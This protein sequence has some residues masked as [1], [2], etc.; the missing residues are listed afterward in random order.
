MGLVMSEFNFKSAICTSREQSERLLALGLKKETADMC[1]QSTLNDVWSPY[2]P[3]AMPYSK[4]EAFDLSTDV[5][6]D[7]PAWSLG[8]LIKDLM[9]QSIGHLELAVGSDYAGY[10][11]DRC[12]SES[13]MW[14]E[15]SSETSD[16]FNN[17]I[18]TIEWLIK[19]GYF[20]KEYLV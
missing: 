15:Y 4:V 18:L 5:F 8:R 2:I 13:G 14:W 19:E 9:P 17:I 7:I 1:L 16:M 6:R 10:Y 3:I 20:N 12:E 11:E